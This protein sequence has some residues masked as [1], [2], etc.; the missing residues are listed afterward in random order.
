MSRRVI[1]VASFFGFALAVLLSPVLPESTAKL[2]N[3]LGLSSA[4]AVTEQPIRAAGQWGQLPV[5][6]TV[7]PLNALFPRIEAAAPVA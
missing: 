7:A 6:T 3:A 5:G 1:A 2:W 4:S